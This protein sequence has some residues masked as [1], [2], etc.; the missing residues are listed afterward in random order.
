MAEHE[1][2]TC[3]WVFDT[4]HVLTTHRNSIHDAQIPNSNCNECGRDFYSKQEK[5]Y[6]SEECHNE[7]V[8]Y[9]GQNNP[10]YRGGKTTTQCDI[11]SSEF[12]Y[13]P[14]EKEGLYCSACVETEDWQDPPQQEGEKNPRWNGGKVELDCTVC[15]ETVSR[16]PSNVTGEVTLCSDDCRYTW[17][18]EA[19]TGASHPNWAGGKSGPYGKGWNETRRNALERDEYECQV[20]GKTKAEIG[21]NPDV[22]HIVP[23]RVFAD[24][25]GY[26]KSDA[27]FLENVV[28]LCVDCHRKAD[29]GVIPK[30][31]LLAR[32][33][34][35][36]RF[37]PHTDGLPCPVV[38]GGGIRKL[39]VAQGNP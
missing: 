33:L 34:G 16:Y 13:Y 6:C 10:N 23:V 24:A 14:S 28:S 27:H 20:C 3:G 31:R 7:A 18:S 2:P 19:F 21:R 17:L 32:V 38:S 11:C 12:K 25:E 35:G 26:E 8:S 1:C 36:V 37:G 15:E 4:D 5:T 29:F 30:T 9:E 39:A 22:H